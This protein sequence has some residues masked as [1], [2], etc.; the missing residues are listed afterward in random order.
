MTLC[1]KSSKARKGV[2]KLKQ[3]PCDPHYTFLMY[4][5]LELVQQAKVNLFIKFK[6]LIFTGSKN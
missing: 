1:E 6:L 4:F 2:P 5:I 3:K